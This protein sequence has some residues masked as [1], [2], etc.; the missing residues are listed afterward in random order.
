MDITPIEAIKL[1]LILRMWKNSNGTE[2]F[3]GGQMN[4]I[5]NP[6]L[7]RIFTRENPTQYI[8]LSL[9]M[10]LRNRHVVVTGAASG[11]GRRFALRFL[12][13]GARVAAWDI[14]EHG[15]NSLSEE[16]RNVC[17]VEG[18]VADR[19]LH[20]YV[21]NVASPDAIQ[22]SA[23]E[24]LSDLDHIDIVLNNAGIVSGDWITD[25]TD[26][27]IE[28]TFAINALAPFRITKAFLPDMITRGNGHIVTIASAGAFLGTPRLSDYCASKSAVAAFDES[29][30]NEMKQRGYPIK[31][32][33]VC[34]FYVDTG[35][36]SGVRTRFSWLL[37]ILKPEKVVE[38][39][40]RAIQTGRTRLI[41]PWFIYTIFPLRLLPTR[42][43]DGLVL[44]FGIMRSMDGFQG[45]SLPVADTDTDTAADSDSIRRI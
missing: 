24:T 40:I 42:L 2:N 35:M 14:N 13:L 17:N 5:T 23:R 34:P 9:F 45:R 27:A 31:T 30:R 7:T 33:L 16:W 1:A 32:T 26:E 20:T 21:C 39:T 29:L 38:R 28:R 36:F 8:S 3:H 19:R 10:E 22:H 18:P 37:P 44:F 4:W 43:F 41:M 12:E 25:L 6:A 15:L 11:M